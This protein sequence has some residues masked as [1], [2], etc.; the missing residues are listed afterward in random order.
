MGFEFATAARILF[1]EGTAGKL[2][3]E[4]AALGTR[5]LVVHGKSGLRAQPL[6]ESLLRA[7]LVVDTVSCPGEPDVALAAAGVRRALDHRADLVVGIGGG[8]ALDLAKAVAALA[9]NPGDPLD[10][11]EVV[12]KGLPLGRPA[13][14]CITVPTTAG[15]GAEVT[16]NAVLGVPEQRV[17]VSLRGLTLLPR[18]AIVDPELTWGLPA[19]Q[20]AY[21]GLDALTQLIEAF[22]CN[23]PNPLTDGFCRD[24]IPRAF[25]AL[26]PACTLDDHRARSD[27]ALAALQSGLALANAKLGAVHGLAGPLGGLLGAP[28]GALC[29]A[30]LPAV[31]QANLQAA[32][33]GSALA[34]RFG[35][36]ASLLTGDLRT[37]AA[38]ALEA[39][40]SLVSRLKVPKLAHWGLKPDQIPGLLPA[41][42]RAGSMKGNPVP[43]S[44]DE[45]RTILLGS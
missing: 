37:G 23:S 15:T 8:S 39:L 13:L 10:Y 27:L 18:L 35:E 44:D 12:G 21:S 2:G 25:R 40:A 33:A 43:L 31:L 34:L 19:D 11:L 7:G 22:V 41:A 28:H 30:L 1:G 32:P 9:S 20:T 45:L 17:K 42:Q 26:E 6:I 16:R 38:G 24:G 3:A 5:V 4:A 29:A 14:P 36:L